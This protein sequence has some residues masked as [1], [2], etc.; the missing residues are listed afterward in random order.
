MR[1]FHL[2]FCFFYGVLIIILYCM[3]I[4]DKYVTADIVEFVYNG[5]NA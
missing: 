2:V 4:R 1:E 3:C 5:E